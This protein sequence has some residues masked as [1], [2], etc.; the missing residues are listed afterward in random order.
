MT[1]LHHPTWLQSNSIPGSLWLPDSQPWPF[2]VQM[3]PLLLKP[4]H[5]LILHKLGAYLPKANLL[6]NHKLST[7]LSSVEQ[8]GWDQVA[9]VGISHCHLLS[10]L[11]EA[12]IQSSFCEPSAVG[13]QLPV[14]GFHYG[15]VAKEDHRLQNPLNYFL[16]VYIFF[17]DKNSL[18]FE[19]KKPLPKGYQMDIKKLIIKRGLSEKKKMGVGE[20][21]V[22]TLK[23]NQFWGK[24]LS[25]VWYDL[26]RK[27]SLSASWSHHGDLQ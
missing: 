18:I 26:L 5:E 6:P 19:F 1:G 3:C 17:C 13:T 27:E 10:S 8:D 16:L 20:K 2:P 7:W 15:N 22:L 23:A 14:T 11:H 12:N 4:P 25:K 9:V 21:M 24:V